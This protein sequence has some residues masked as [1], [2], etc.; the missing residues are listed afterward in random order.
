MEMGSK[1]KTGILG[2]VTLIVLVLSIV[3]MAVCFSLQ[4]DLRRMSVGDMDDARLV[5]GTPGNAPT[6]GADTPEERH[7]LYVLKIENGELVVLDGGGTVLRS[8]NPNAG[9]LPAGDVAMLKRGID[10]DSEE[11]L[12]SLIEDFSS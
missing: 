8:V 12:A 4:S 3:T 6:E 11:E 2:F 9:F 5:N 10:I 1:V 7:P